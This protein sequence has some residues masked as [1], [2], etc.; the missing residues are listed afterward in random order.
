MR[1]HSNYPPGVT[2]NEPEIT[3]GD[4]LFDRWM[5]RVDAYL[6]SK[7][8]LNSADLPDCCYRD[9]FDD[10]IGPVLAARRAIKSVNE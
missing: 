9:W 4:E 10:G 6:E 8:G 2:G 5:E 7:L 3:G 1:E